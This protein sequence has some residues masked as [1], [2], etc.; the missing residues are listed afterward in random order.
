MVPRPV[1]P[2]AC[3]QFQGIDPFWVKTALHISLYV[4]NVSLVEMKVTKLKENWAVIHLG[5]A[6]SLPPQF[7]TNIDSKMKRTLQFG[8]RGTHK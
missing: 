8:T 1:A 7:A 5:Q 2:N 6:A 3:N 4:A